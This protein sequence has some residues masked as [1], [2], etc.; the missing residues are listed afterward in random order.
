M[1]MA[2]HQILFRDHTGEVSKAF[3]LFDGDEA[4]KRSF[5]NLKCVAKGACMIVMLMVMGSWMKNKSCA[6]RGQAIWSECLVGRHLD[7]KQK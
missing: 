4:V 7:V 5:E 6:S 1:K 3:H 2:N